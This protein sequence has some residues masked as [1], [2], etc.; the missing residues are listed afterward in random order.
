MRALYTFGVLLYATAVYLASFVNPKAKA[1][2]Q[3]R[4]NWK[5]QLPTTT[6]KV[7]WFH[8][9]SLGEFDQG[10]P[11]MN[12]LKQNDPS[13]FLLVTFFSPSGMEHYHKRQHQV[14]HA[15]YLPIDTKRNATYLI[16]HFNPASCFI[17]KYEFWCNLLIAAD[18]LRMPVFSVSTLLR[19][20]HRFFKWYGA[21]FRKALR[22]VNYFF[23]QNQETADLLKSIRIDRFK[24]T[25]DT[26]FDRVIENKSQVQANPTLETFLNGTKAIIIGSSW[27]EDEVIL[28]PYLRLHPEE[29]FILAPH[30]ISESHVQSI[31]RTLGNQACRYSNYATEFE[32]NILILNTI[33]HLASAYSYGKIAY[34][35]GGFSGKLHNIL[36][37]AVFGL[38]VIFGPEH[39]RFPEAKLFLQEQIAFSVS[40]TQEL[41]SAIHSIEHQLD[42]FIARA[43]KVVE[44]NRGASTKI[45][46]HLQNNYP[47]TI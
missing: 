3:G 45:Y 13:I 25:G 46:H 32:G 5:Q 12:Q 9:A 17:I 7:V 38:P 31:E 20:K 30:D 22:S 37:P 26:R 23:V 28:L 4:K 14:D 42:R 39:S 15:L 29:K 40:T 2:I 16:Q 6:K 35:G 36:E 34:I 21:F 43:T 8:C 44:D 47:N 24:I 11:L 27:P 1:W 41:N 33:G 19:E 10:L 18:E